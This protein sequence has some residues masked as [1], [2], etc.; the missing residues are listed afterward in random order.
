MKID[1]SS[2][3]I[4]FNKKDSRKIS[5]GDLLNKA[6]EWVL[7]DLIIFNIETEYSREEND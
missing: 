1:N 7:F 2:N 3:V 4:T 6:N 5:N